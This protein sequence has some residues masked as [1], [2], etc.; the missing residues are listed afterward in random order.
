MKKILSFVFLALLTVGCNKYD[1]SELRGIIDAQ[2]A[3][4]EA[5]ARQIAELRQITD[6]LSAGDFVTGVEPIK[7]GEAT[8]GITVVF[9]TGA[10]VV[11]HFASGNSG[12][13]ITGATVS[14]GELLLSLLSG[15]TVRIAITPVPVLTL[16]KEAVLLFPGGNATVNYTVTGGDAQNSVQALVE[17]LW[18]AEVVPASATAGSVSLTA[19]DPCSD[20]KVVLMVTSGAGKSSFKT[21]ACAEARFSVAKNTW[22]AAAEAGQLQVPVENNLGTFTVEIPQEATWLTTESVTETAVTFAL[23]ENTGEERSATVKLKNEAYDAEL[24]VEVVQ[25]DGGTFIWTPVT[26]AANVVAGDCIL[27]F[28]RQSDSKL[29]FIS[30]ATSITRNPVAVEAAA[31]GVTFSGDDITAVDPAYV[32]KVAASGSYW[33]FAGTGNLWLIGANKFQG[34]AVLSDLKGYYQST[35]TYARTWSFV[36]DVNYGLQMLVTESAARHLSVGD[37]S[38]V[39]SMVPELKG[40]IILYYKTR[41]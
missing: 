24:A 9:H 32:W 10:P 3:R 4:I 41:L 14:E 37:E 2:D 6:A 27:A 40:H 5:L 8:V 31:A 1:D 19:P 36:D 30:G 34:A 18:S 13:G 23:T 17:G 25:A 35:D 16:E 29:F 7:E 11:I 12:S 15:Q 22:P 20:A 38:T 26:T 28:L 39:W 21:I 33:T